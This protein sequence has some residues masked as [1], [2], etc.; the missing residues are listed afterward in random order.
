MLRLLAIA[1]EPV[2]VAELFGELRSDAGR[3]ALVESIEALRRRSLV[4][5]AELPGA[6]AFTLQ[7]VVLE[8]VTDQLVDA[9]YDAVV[10][11]PSAVL[12]R[13]LIQ[14]LAREYVRQSQE[15]LIGEPIVQR[16]KLQYGRG[17]RRSSCWRCWRPGA[18][19]RD[20]IVA[21]GLATW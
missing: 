4:E 21:T 20:A 2:T 7:S 11:G 3:G 14:G 18:G 15:R 6:A 16:L 13:P 19:N 10:H 12:E 1:R 5:R 8:Y 9:V 17:S